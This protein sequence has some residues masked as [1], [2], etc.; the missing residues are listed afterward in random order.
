MGVGNVTNNSI[1]IYIYDPITPSILTSLPNQMY[2]V[3]IS[4]TTPRAFTP[5]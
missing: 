2:I 4:T 5:Y 1:D 3:D